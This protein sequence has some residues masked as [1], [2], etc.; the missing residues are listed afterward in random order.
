[1]KKKCS[2]CNIEKELIEFNKDKTSPDGLGYRCRECG[3]TYAKQYHQDN[4]EKYKA[5]YEKNRDKLKEKCIKYYYKNRE[6][7]CEKARQYHQDNKERLNE[8]TKEWR[9]KNIEHIKQYNIKNKERTK[10]FQK[11][12]RE[13]NKE[14]I[15]ERG[16][17]YYQK[18]K[19]KLN[20]QGAEW[21]DR[22]KE[23][24]NEWSRKYIKNKLLHNNL[25]KLQ[26]TIRNSINNSIRNNGYKKKSRTCE[27]LGCSYEEFKNHIESQWEEWMNWDNHGGYYKGK[28]KKKWDLDH[29]IPLASANT[30]EE[31]IKLNHYTNFQPLCSYINRHIKKDLLDWDNLSKGD[32]Y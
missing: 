18:N 32:I 22:N 1:M 13:N 29:V 10:E 21:R 25:F 7:R 27:I 3:K 23:R 4:K 15:K 26:M 8:Y 17:K 19:E 14:K 9:E 30:E 24:A 20:Q 31:I 2:Q 12:Y 11:Q 6:K 28:E 5:Y 16:Q